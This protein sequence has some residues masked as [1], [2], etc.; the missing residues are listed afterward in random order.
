MCC[1]EGSA[2]PRLLGDIDS[3][4]PPVRVGNLGKGLKNCRTLEFP[5]VS[6]WVCYQC[7]GNPLLKHDAC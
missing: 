6:K 7:T 4:F 1:V 5:L 2:N 3:D